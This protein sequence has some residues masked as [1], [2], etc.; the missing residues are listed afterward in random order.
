M[1]KAKECTDHKKNKY[2]S[3]S[4]MCKFYKINP[5]TVKC[6][7]EKGWSLEEALTKPARKKVCVGKEYTDPKGRVH[8]NFKEMCKFYGIS[9]MSVNSRLK[10]GMSLEEALIKP[11]KKPRECTDPEGRVYKSFKDMCKPYGTKAI[12]VSMRIGKGIEIFVALTCKDTVSLEFIGL[13]GKA[14]YKLKGIE[15]LLTTRQIIEK[16]RPDLVARYDEVN[17]EGKYMPPNEE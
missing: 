5:L 12:T 13:D 9:V 6:R 14:Y 8:S 2:K 15:E 10:K 7:L 16:Y 17:P 11:A 1:P 3:F 4:D